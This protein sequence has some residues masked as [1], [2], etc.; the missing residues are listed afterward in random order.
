[1]EDG[2]KYFGFVSD[3]FASGCDLL[4]HIVDSEKIP[5][6][7]KANFIGASFYFFIIISL[8]LTRQF[9]SDPLKH[10]VFL[11]VVLFFSVMLSQLNLKY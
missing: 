9:S 7:G 3:C 4:K 10:G 8:I 11:V 5:W 2:G 6:A 1:M